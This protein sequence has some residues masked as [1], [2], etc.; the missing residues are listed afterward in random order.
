MIKIITGDAAVSVA[1]GHSREETVAR[2][3]NATVCDADAFQLLRRKT[4]TTKDP[5]AAAA[6]A[7]TSHPANPAINAGEF[8]LKLGTALLM[9]FAST[10]ALVHME[11]YLSVA[12]S[13]ADFT[14]IA[15]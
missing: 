4:M 7:P 2:I 3:L 15:F 5:G 10:L 9:V 1:H 6:L 11:I 8:A 12:Q 13:T 14:N